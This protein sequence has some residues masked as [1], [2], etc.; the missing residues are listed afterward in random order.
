MMM[1][2]IC[3]AALLV[4]GLTLF[5]G[6]GLGSLLMPVFALFF[7]LPVAVA[8]TAVVH[9]LN[10]VFK[11]GLLFRE[12]DRAVLLRFGVPAIVAALPGALLLLQLSGLAPWWV[13]QWGERVCAITPL[14]FTMGIL[15]LGFLLLE[16]KPLGRF[17][18]GTR[19]LWMGGIASG[20]FGGLSGHQGA[21]RALFLRSQG[22]TPAAFAATQAMIAIGV[23]I[24][25]LLVYGVAFFAVQASAVSEAGVWPVVLAATV[26]AF[27]GSYAGSRYLKKVRHEWVQALTAVMLGLV[28]I[29]LASGVI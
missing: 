25:R 10:N 23:D 17:T 14:K 27:I 29:G 11:A 21:L 18:P 5:S 13:W 22:M 9:L 20:F 12:V 2:V 16:L 28:G 4:A 24:T 1:W 26:S 3:L 15:I 8:A 19:V 6:F 7:P